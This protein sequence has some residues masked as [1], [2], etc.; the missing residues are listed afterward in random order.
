MLIHCGVGVSRS[1][2]VFLAYLI[3]KH[4]YSLASAFSIAKRR[5]PIVKISIFRSIR[6]KAL[7]KLL[8]DIAR[9]TVVK[10]ATQNKK[11]N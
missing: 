1:V 6:T 5:R 11:D 10:T 7:L 2:A 9:N 4:G 3:K 8:R